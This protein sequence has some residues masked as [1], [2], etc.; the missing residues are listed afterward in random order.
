M[1]LSSLCYYYY[2]AQASSEPPRYYRIIRFPFSFSPPIVSIDDNIKFIYI[3]TQY[4]CC[5]VP[6]LQEVAMQQR[7]GNKVPTGTY[8]LIAI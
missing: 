3:S 1:K 5:L 7:V 6:V 4:L 2:G 8:L